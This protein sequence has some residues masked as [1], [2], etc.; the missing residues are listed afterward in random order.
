M[1]WHS[2]V[3]CGIVCDCAKFRGE[4][5]QFNGFCKMAAVRHLGFFIRVFGGLYHCAKFGCNH[6]SSFD[7]MQVLIFYEL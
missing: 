5:L 3:Q 4:I 2:E 6:Y 7:N 1:S